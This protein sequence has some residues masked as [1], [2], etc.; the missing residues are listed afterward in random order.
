MMIKMI[1]TWTRFDLLEYYKF[2]N[3]IEK[4]ALLKRRQAGWCMVCG[5][6]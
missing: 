2:N 5:E 6:I 4:I 1:L 3:E